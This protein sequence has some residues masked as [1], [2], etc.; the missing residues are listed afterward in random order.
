M[1]LKERIRS[2][3]GEFQPDVVACRRHLHKNPE[4]SFH[5]F[6]T[7]KF[8]EMKLK[9]F[10]ITSMQRMANTG[11]VAIVEGKNPSNKVIALRGDMD[12]LPIQETNNIEYKSA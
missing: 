7:Q 8:V 2:L 12:A 3:A 10:G 5:E 6:N 11:V 1:N 9:E 4:L